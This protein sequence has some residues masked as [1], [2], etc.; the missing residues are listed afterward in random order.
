MNGVVDSGAVSIEKAIVTLTFLSAA[1][2]EVSLT[3]W[4]PPL[5]PRNE[6]ARVHSPF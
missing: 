2:L 6:K 4:I 5:I 1:G 3:T